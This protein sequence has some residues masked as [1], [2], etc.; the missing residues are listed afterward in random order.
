MAQHIWLSRRAQDLQNGVVQ[1]QANLTEVDIE[2]RFSLFLRYQTTND[3]GFH[4]C[5]D[6]LAR[7]RA[8]KRKVEIGFERQKERNHAREQAEIREHERA[9][10]QADRHKMAMLLEEAK[11]HHQFLLN[12]GLE[13][14]NSAAA[15]LKMAA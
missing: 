3:H 6:Q 15:K 12:T 2:R 7:L 11:L 8:E 14:A 9:G 13:A 5:L 1:N 10:R 4:K